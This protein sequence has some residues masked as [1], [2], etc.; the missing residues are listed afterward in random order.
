MRSPLLIGFFTP[1]NLLMFA[2]T[3]VAGLISAWWLFPLGLLL[4]F[5]MVLNVARDPSLK[6][7]QQIESRSPLT[8]RFQSKFSRIQRTQINLFNQMKSVS[9]EIRILSQ[10]L[11]EAFNQLVDES[12]LLCRRL[13]P[14]ENYLVTSNTRDSIRAEIEMNKITL[15]K[16]TDALLRKEYEENQESLYHRLENLES[17]STQ[18]NRAEA[19]LV[20]VANELERYVMDILRFQSMDP[21]RVRERSSEI[22]LAVQIMIGQ[23]RSTDLPSKPLSE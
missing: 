11:Q 4:W 8:Q 21:N 10:P 22:L 20:N 23:V 2:C 18:L 3:V 15:E 13:T 5:W 19:E 14:L 17:I 7:N 6:L 9:P 1:L 12:Y 16:T